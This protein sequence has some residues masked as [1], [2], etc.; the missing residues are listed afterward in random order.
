MR[1]IFFFR[2]PEILK[3]RDLTGELKEIWSSVQNFRDKEKAGMS[4]IVVYTDFGPESPSIQPSDPNEP[5]CK[6]S[7][8]SVEG[9]AVADFAMSNDTSNV[10]RAVSNEK[11][12]A[13]DNGIKSADIE[14]LSIGDKKTGAK[15]VEESRDEIVKLQNQKNKS[16]S[17]FFPKFLSSSKENSTKAAKDTKKSLNFFRRNKSSSSPTHTP[18]DNATN[19][20]KSDSDN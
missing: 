17:N 20:L 19:N 18:S 5:Y 4:D 14:N 10:E 1:A 7:E 3:D 16:Q 13:F 15:K 12:H 6:D 11:G 2:K 9:E 8:K